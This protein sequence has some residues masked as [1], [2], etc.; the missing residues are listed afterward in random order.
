MDFPKK[1]LSWDIV[2]NNIWSSAKR[3]T[4]VTVFVIVFSKQHN[5]DVI[6]DVEK[7]ENIPTI[8]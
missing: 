5:R 7:N 8:D 4:I 3:L 2:V 1:S 6:I